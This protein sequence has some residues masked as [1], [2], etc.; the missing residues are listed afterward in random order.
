MEAEKQIHRSFMQN[1]YLFRKKVFKIFGGAF[2][3]Y[4]DDQTLLFYSKQKAFKLKEDFRI[5]ADE[6]MAEELLT[7]KTPQIFDL[8]ATY[9]VHDPV[10]DEPVGALRR[11]GLKSLF[12]DE[13]VFLSAEGQ[14]IAKL[15][16]SSVLAALCS[17][18]INL[19][20]QKYVIVSTDGTTI[21]E[22]KQHF[23]PFV[24]KYTMTL[25]QD[26]PAIDRRLIVSAGILLASI[27]GRQQS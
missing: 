17:R 22:I 6:R 2:H 20:P 19:I 13:W 7:I 27:E 3:V 10:A 11:K 5:Y 24:L 15:T 21:A 14:E 25:L 23:N 8:G 4:G 26:N 12:K 16:E 18:F 9:Y 1:Q